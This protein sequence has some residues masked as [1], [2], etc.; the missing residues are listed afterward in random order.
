MKIKWLGHSSFLITSDSGV[1]II[2]DPYKPGN[3]IK[4]GAINEA[5]DIVTVSH[6]HFDH[7]NVSE[8]QGNPTVVKGSTDAKGIHF[9]GIS[10]Y[11]DDTQG[12][13]R[14]NENL[15]E[16]AGRLVCQVRRSDKAQ[17]H[18]K[19]AFEAQREEDQA[20]GCSKAEL[21]ANVPQGQGVKRG[22]NCRDCKERNV[23][24]RPAA[25]IDGCHKETTHDA[26][27]DHGWI[28]TNQEDI[29]H[30]PR[31]GEPACPAPSK[32]VGEDEYKDAAYDR[33]IESADDENMGSTR[34]VI[35]LVQVS[36]DAGLDAQQNTL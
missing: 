21:K 5:A 8:V 36:G 35:V 1:K 11:H 10:A 29:N 6:D 4:Y 32:K 13:Q 30:N 3:G 12:S 19:H 18:P 9:K 7:C 28:G 33:D 34:R 31:Q 24:R 23:S 2:T 22:Q 14:G 15:S 25:Q 27:T 26:S 16:C 17:T 20:Q